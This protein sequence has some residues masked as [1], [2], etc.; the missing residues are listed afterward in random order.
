MQLIPGGILGAA[1]KHIPCD[2][3]GLPDA[4]EE[5]VTT[6]RGVLR[7]LRDSDDDGRHDQ[8]EGNQNAVHRSL[9]QTDCSEYV[10]RTEL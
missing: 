10:G 7:V 4:I 1:I 6:L 2:E 3:A 9:S 8:R 5:L